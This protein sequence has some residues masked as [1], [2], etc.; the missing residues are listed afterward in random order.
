MLKIVKWI[1]QEF[2]PVYGCPEFIHDEDVGKLNGI[3][4]DTLFQL[5]STAGFVH[6]SGKPFPNKLGRC[7]HG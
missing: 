4:A 2:G 1:S 6:E 5:K 3:A 7:Q